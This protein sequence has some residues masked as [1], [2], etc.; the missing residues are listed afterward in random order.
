MPSKKTVKRARRD[1]RQ[2][3]KPST[4]A[5]EFVKEEFDHIRQGKHGARSTKQAIAIALSKARRAGVPLKPPKRGTVPETTRKS[6]ERAY[7]VGQRSP[8]APSPRRSRASLRTLRREG[9][10]AGTRKAISS[11]VRASARKIRRQ[12]TST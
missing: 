9:R 6:A 5:G 3:K 4:A 8:H 2:G 7:E 12:R 1:L 10:A 11:Q